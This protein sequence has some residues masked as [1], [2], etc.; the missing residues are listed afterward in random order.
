[1]LVVCGLLFFTAMAASQRPREDAVP[2]HFVP[3][4]P[5]T[6][7][8]S[9]RGQVSLTLDVREDPRTRVPAFYFRGLETAPLIRVFPGD[10]I[11]IVLRNDLFDG[12]FMVNDVSLHF[13]GLAVSPNPP[14]DDVLM[15][16]AHPGQAIRYVVHVPH[17]QYSGLY[18]Y[19][20]HAHGETYWQVT[21]GLSGAIIVEP[22][23]RHRPAPEV[24]RERVLVLRDAQSAPSVWAVPQESRRH[25]NRLLARDPRWRYPRAEEA[26]RNSPCAPTAGMHTTVNG[27]PGVTVQTAPGERQL[28][29]VINASAKRYFDLAADG[30]PLTIVA[31]D[32]APL[33]TYPGTDHSSRAVPHFVLPPSGRIE[34]I[35][36]GGEEPRFLRS[37]CYDAGAAGESDPPVPLAQLRPSPEVMPIRQVPAAMAV[38]ASSST[39][40]ALPLPAPARSRTIRLTEDAHGYYINDRMF[41]MGNPPLVVRSGTV[42]R[43]TVLNLTDEVHVFHI[44]QV[45]FA[46][47]D[48]NGHRIR[49]PYWADTVTIRP[50]TVATGGHVTPG[51]ATLLVDFR[52]PV[53][54]G[55]FVFHCHML[56]HE[57]GGMMA[58][59]RA[60]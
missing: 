27:V 4:R 10:T 33:S 58:T 36:S 31:I 18:W 19:H 49:Q 17:S 57:D 60:I 35:L 41:D 42:E 7:A 11:R 40:E 29:R 21:S 39:S 14:G 59:I 43:W 5:L 37:L 1:M 8:R 22:P 28:F 15:T 56:D 23:T 24:M 25:A 34:F 54:R 30:Q 55:T 47:I 51:T 53:I 50:R 38:P 26:R 46:A 13:H 6:V 52:D 20:S 2:P 48:E 9:E 45:H 3:Y 16:V 32:G 12:D 44:H